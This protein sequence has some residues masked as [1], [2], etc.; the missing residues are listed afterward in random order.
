MFNV[1]KNLMSSEKAVAS[2]VLVLASSVMVLTGELTPQEWMEYTQTL[3]GIY[4]GGKTVQGVAAAMSGRKQ[5]EEAKTAKANEA[6]ALAALETL[7]EKIA[8]N[9]SAADDAV[10]AKFGK[11]DPDDVDTD[12]GKVP[13]SSTPEG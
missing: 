10:D 9:D 13:H 8:G 11:K 1:I 4:V 12:P 3:L 7:K 2:G 5:S 6:Q